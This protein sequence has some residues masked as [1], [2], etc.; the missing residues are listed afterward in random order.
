MKHTPKPLIE[1]HYHIEEL[2]DRQ[3]ARV[4]DRRYHK[5]RIKLREERDK[6]IATT[7]LVQNMNFYCERCKEDFVAQSIRQIEVDWT[8][9]NQ[10]IA[11]YRSKCSKGHWCIRLITDKH[12]DSYFARSLLLAQDRRKHRLDVLQNYETGYNLMYGK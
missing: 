5:E 2:I 1:E 9:E 11:F 10:N 12:L 3:E 4:K 7:K 6:E 8:N